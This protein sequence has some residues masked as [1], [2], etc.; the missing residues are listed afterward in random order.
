[1]LAPAVA[2][3]PGAARSVPVGAPAPPIVHEVL[4]SAGRPLDGGTRAFMEQRFGHDFGRVR[5]HTDA[6]AAESARAVAARAWTVGN[7][8]AFGAGAYAPSTAEGRHLLAHELTHVLQ[9]GDGIVRRACDTALVGARTEP[10]FFPKQAKLM[11]V[12]DGN[13]TLKRNAADQEAVG[14]VQQALVDLCHGGGISGPNRDGVDRTFGDDTA[15]T[16]KAFQAAQGLAASG[17]VDLTT[18]RC[19]DEARAR[20]TLPCKTGVALAQSDLELERRIAGGRNE[21]IYFG[22][23]KQTL[24]SSNAVKAALLAVKYRERP[25]TL[26]GFVSEDELVD[27]GPGLARERIAAVDAEIARAGHAKVRTPDAQPAASGGIPNY[28]KRR[29]VEVRAT[30]AG[31]KTA[32]CKSVPKGWTLP[33]QGPCNTEHEE[34]VKNAI[35]RGVQLM[36]IAIGLLTPGDPIAEKAVEDRFGDRTLVPSIRADLVGWMDH[37]KQFVRANHTCTN[38]CHGACEN[39]RAYT[40]KA[41]DT[42]ICTRFL[43]LPTATRVQKDRQALIMV[44]EAG[45]GFLKTRDIAYDDTRLVAL[46]HKTPSFAR[47]NTDS[48]ILVIQCLSGVTIDGSSC[49]VSPPGDTFPGLGGPP[50]TDQAAEALAW[51]ERWM[52]FGWQGVNSLYAAIEVARKAGAW[53]PDHAFVNTLMPFFAED[54]GLRRPEGNPPPTFREQTAVAAVHDHYVT[55]KAV[56]KKN[57]GRELTE[58]AT[59]VPEWVDRARVH[60]VVVPPGF[61]TGMGPR[62]RV[63]FLVKLLVQAQPGVSRAAVPSYVSLTEKIAKTFFIDAPT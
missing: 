29:K 11:D 37:L 63:R 20:R 25:L 10:V 59:A 24:T 52:D 54:F 60:T 2:R 47:I 14:L 48:Y 28:P 9:Q 27:S 36:G 46:L 32:S 31:Q 45:H 7:D 44:H 38:E 13:D 26:T 51:T 3:N 18:L 34:I 4:G 58:S 5:V 8:V 21:D 19:L 56:T 17:E 35:D 49:T 55:M 15:K 23:G 61:F 50:K 30:G 57:I 43:N 53:H 40:T 41:K 33:D 42:F 22:R 1:V 39:T 62:D 16:V 6:R 12:F